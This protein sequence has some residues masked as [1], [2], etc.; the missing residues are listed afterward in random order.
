MKTIIKNFLLKNNKILRNNKGV[1][2]IEIMVGIGLLSIVAVIAVPQFQAYQR[3]AKYGVLRSM[4]TVPFRTM[5]VELSLG[6]AASSASAGFL[7]ARVK[8]KAKDSFNTPI[9]NSS[10]DDWCFFIE[11]K[12]GKNYADFTG[13]IDDTGTIEI[14]GKNVPCSQGRETKK[15]TSASTPQTPAC[16]HTQCPAGCKRKTGESEPSCSH[17]QTN[18]AHC[19][20]AGQEVFTRSPAL[21]CNSSGD[22]V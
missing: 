11:G 3:E 22:C 6:K 8:S 18:E 13:C 2:L 14:G 21:T 5:E 9:F 7:W 15:P 17:T 4:L 10:G 20:P 19:E 16:T 12:S 1:S